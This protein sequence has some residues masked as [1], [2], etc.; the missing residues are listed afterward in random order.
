[1][2]SSED[3]MPDWREY[4]RTNLQLTSASP[5]QESEAIED[6]ARHLEDAYSDALK[7]GCSPDVAE[8]EARS[9]ISDWKRLSRELRQSPRYRVSSVERFASETPRGSGVA[10]LDSLRQDVRFSIRTFV[11]KPAF[12]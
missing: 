11:R 1:M 7:R 3:G 8:A 12:F 2:R 4:V 5:E 9:H 6:L 10:W